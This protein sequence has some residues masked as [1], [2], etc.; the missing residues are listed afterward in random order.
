MLESKSGSVKS[1]L[2]RSAL[3]SGLVGSGASQDSRTGVTGTP[4]DG[5]GIMGRAW[6]A[7]KDQ[8]GRCCPSMIFSAR[9]VPEGKTCLAQVSIPDQQSQ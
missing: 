5:P 1:D 2:K 9:E 4:E 3:L 6:S 8:R 7:D